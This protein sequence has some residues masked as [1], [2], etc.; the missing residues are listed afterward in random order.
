MPTIKQ[1][2]DSFRK[3]EMPYLKSINRDYKYNKMMLLIEERWGDEDSS[4]FGPLKFQQLRDELNKKKP[5]RSYLNELMTMLIRIMRHGVSMELYPPEKLSALQAVKPLRPDQCR[6]D[7]P[8]KK[9]TLEQVLEAVAVLPDPLNDMVMLQVLT[10]ARPS[11]LFT[12][13]PKEIE[14]RDE[15][16]LI[17]KQRH[18]TLHHGKQRV[19]VAV[20]QAKG[21]LQRRIDGLPFVNARGKAWTKDGYRRALH[22]GLRNNGLEVFNPYQLRHLSAQTVRDNGNAED[23]SALLGHSSLSLVNTYSDA[24]VERAIEAAKLIDAKLKNSS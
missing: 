12:L 14:Q 19:L 5:A 17:V 10:G 11:E 23:V 1:I 18:K 24:S 9:V 3:R 22:R 8:K 21:I 4:E 16:W 20:G 7:Q 2:C 6:P 15:V 13:M